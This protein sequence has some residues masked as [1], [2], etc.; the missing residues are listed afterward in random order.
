MFAYL[1]QQTYSSGA[2]CPGHF[3][4]MLQEQNGNITDEKFVL[5]YDIHQNR[6]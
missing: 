6:V 3:L 4:E 5:H 2:Y 1:H